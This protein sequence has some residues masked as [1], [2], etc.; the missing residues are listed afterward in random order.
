MILK[1]LLY[2]LAFISIYFSLPFQD[3][4]RSNPESIHWL[5]LTEAVKL[6]AVHPKKI[7]I[8]VYTHWCGWCKKMDYSTFS[9]K[10]IIQEM[11]EDYY[12][13]K[14][15][16]ETKDSIQFMNHSF[17][18]LSP[19]QANEI[20]VALLGGKMG[21]PTT[22]LMDENQKIITRIPGYLDSDQLK[23]ILVYFGKN[24]H[25]KT[26]WNVYQ[27]SLGKDTLGKK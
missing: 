20:A 21:Y 22:V 12:P 7:Y 2:P 13:V 10:Q 14:L 27:K 4:I 15:D 18:Y 6:N 9:D 5:S 1:N 3:K 8:D 25:L 16:A 19:Y 17:K 23:D 26:S 11:N 24:I